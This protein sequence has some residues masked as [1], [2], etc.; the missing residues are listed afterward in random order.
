M[1][2]LNEVRDRI[3]AAVDRSGRDPSEITLVAVTKAAS[4]EAILG[5][6]E[7]GQR[8]FGENRADRLAS[9]ARLLPEA[10]WHMIGRLQGN[11]VRV[12][13]DHT[14]LLHSLD[15]PDLAGYWAK[16]PEP[17]PPVLI[18]VNVGNDPAKA[19]VPADRT[20]DLVAAAVGLGL[21]VSGL[22]T[23]P[24]MTSDP[25]ETRVHFRAMASLRRAVAVEFPGV[26]ELSMGMTDDFEVAIEECAT[27]LRVGRAIFGA[28]EENRG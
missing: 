23:I 26:T 1:G 22:M 11:K 3:A 4:P 15:R 12:V 27:V 25:E 20:A 16:G 17:A 7:A 14:A 9:G 24:P 21:E 18:Q 19:G 6:F 28:F 2:G 8:D 13:R 10:N 5:A